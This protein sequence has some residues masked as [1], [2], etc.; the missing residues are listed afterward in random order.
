[1]SPAIFKKDI[2]LHLYLI[3]PLSFVIIG[4]DVFFLNG[5][6]KDSAVFSLNSGYVSFAFL[7]FIHIVASFFVVLDSEVI[8]YYKNKFLCASFFISTF[9]ILVQYFSFTKTFFIVAIVA[10]LLHFVG[11]QLGVSHF[12]LKKKPKVFIFWYLSAVLFSLCLY[13][14]LFAPRVDVLF[15]YRNLLLVS[16]KFIFCAFLC[17]C[18]F[19]AKGSDFKGWLYILGNVFF[20]ASFTL[21]FKWGYPFFSFIIARILHDVTAFWFYINHG[22]NKSQNSNKNFMYSL[23]LK[24]SLPISISYIV[25]SVLIAFLITK[26]RA[27]MI[28]FNIFMIMTLF[29]YYVEGFLWKGGAPER[30]YVPISV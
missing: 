10:N 9:I 2:L 19:V 8:R 21:F 6:L 4:V 11:Q 24:F 7:S 23:W 16:A 1:M 26:F 20:I 27:N 3:I 29:H 13:F 14:G 17:T 25:F 30:K 28:V 5:R 15:P 22:Q 12:F 18:Y